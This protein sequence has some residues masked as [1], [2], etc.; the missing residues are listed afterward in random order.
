MGAGIRIRGLLLFALLGFVLFGNV[1]QLQAQGWFNTSWNYRVPVT[2]NNPGGTPLNNFQVN[3]QLTNTFNF[4]GTRPNGADLVATSG[5]GVTQIAFYIESWNAPTSA[6]IWV[7]VP[8]I[9][10][11]G[12]T[13]YLYYGNPSAT[14]ASNGDATFLF[15]EDFNYKLPASTFINNALGWEA[16]AQDANPNGGVAYWYQVNTL[17]WAN[18]DY[19]EV[20]GYTIPTMYD[21]AAATSDPV[22]AANLRSRAAQMANF[23]VNAQSADGSWGA[24]FDTGQV[25]DGLV[26]AYRETNNV[27]YLN[28]ATRAASFLISKQSGD[29]SWPSDFGGFAKAYDARVA[30]SLVLLWQVTGTTSYQTAA[31]KNLNWVVGQQSSNGWFQSNGINSTAENSGPLTHTIAYTMEGLLDSGI[32]LSN[33]T[34]INAAKKAADALLARQLATG[35]L[36]GGTYRSDWTPGTQQQCVTGDAQTA[37][38]WLKYYQY[39]VNIG[40]PNPQYLTAA[41]KLNQYLV[42]VQGTSSNPGING[43]MAGS[44]PLVGFY[45]ANEILSWATKFFI[46]SLLLQTKFDGA[47]YPFYTLNSAKWLQPSGPGGFFNTGGALQY[48]GPETPGGPLAI[49]ANGGTKISFT[50]GVVEYSLQG[51]AGFGE[52]AL[53]YR[54]Q[55]PET[56]NSYALYPSIWGGQN[57]WISSDLVNGNYNPLGSG[58]SYNLGTTYSVKAVINASTHTLSINNA[59]V[60]STTDSTFSSGSVG[61]L[62][63]GNTINTIGPIR[64]R[65]YAAVDP[66]VSVGT[67]QLSSPSIVSLTFSQNP[68][69]GGNGDT[70][71][72]TLNV[73]TGGTVNLSSSNSSVAG[74]PTSVQIP[75]G[76]SSANFP[77]TTSA[78]TVTSMVTISGTFATSS[79]QSN[80]MV[81]PGIRS[82]GFNPSPVIGG[83]ASTGTVTLAGPAPSGGA[84]I[85]LSSSNTGLATVPSSV[86]IAAGSTST[87]F[88]INTSGVGSSQN[89]TI[90]A[91]FDSSTGSAVLTVTPA[92]L[93][94]LTVSPTSV[95]AGAPATGT[96][97][98][99]GAAPS[100]GASVNVTSSNT[101]AATVPNPVIVN[102]GTNQANFQIT[103]HNTGGP[104]SSLITATYQ[105]QSFSQNLQIVQSLW[106]NPSWSRRRAVSVPNP[107]GSTLTNFQVHVVLSSS[108]TF[109]N[110]QSNGGDIRFTASDG[111]TLLPHW[112]ENW[113]PGTSASI[114]VQVSSVPTSGTT[115]FMYYGNPAAPNVSNGNAVFNFFDDFSYT[116]GGSP[117]I[118]PNKWSFPI[119]Q[120]GFNNVG[121]ALQ[122]NASFGFGP[123]AIAM[124]GGV[125]VTFT[126]G[127]V[128]YNLQGNGPWDE[129]GLV[130]RGQNPETAN[131]YVFYQSVW[132]S[133]NKWLLYARINNTDNSLG[134]GGS[135]SEGVWYAL[136]AAV[137]G[138]SH[139]F[140]V[141]GTPIFSL[142]DS[143]FASGTVGLI[144]WG[145]ATATVS[146]FRIRQYAATDPVTSVGPETTGP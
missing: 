119:G 23:E 26:R 76:Q 71:T 48:Y 87:N 130:Y 11:G 131:S 17:S 137:G 118:D 38:V 94:S 52:M 111:A 39:T 77:I 93:T 72:V 40:S 133:Q 2:I 57:D 138:S 35:Q 8:S 132:N 18:Q 43:G 31:I 143:T 36:S 34:Y 12:T 67:Q 58:G 105:G 146:N 22:Q 128:E 83:N 85:S 91:A 66:T 60:L 56:N 144:A 90:S 6:S 69:A 25:V 64:I 7:R 104:A 74:V 81:V 10:A 42:G 45:R 62:G 61:L 32:I 84:V 107:T 99:N 33:S 106:Y 80:L 124:N 115:I 82:V 15:F 125:P 49:A 1:G 122:Y 13:V 141:N 4:A 126:N 78:V 101:A 139:A 3:I 59:Q 127:I 120:L 44:D 95:I 53:M 129:L 9:P 37:L 29:G 27:Q 102:G 123:R 50:N 140:S 135:F 108:F 55:N 86:T 98:L 142:S 24:I 114:W 65:Q 89:V 103:T 121:G 113:T 73:T 116:S 109:A 63:W 30:R 51:S 96:I 117:A 92:A 112:I 97:T 16:A 5:D 20:T 54:G 46:D 79:V 88:Q 68:I 145:N 19:F 136:K 70:G 14:S 21:A 110:A 28:S 41:R 134:S 75:A 100:G 47:S